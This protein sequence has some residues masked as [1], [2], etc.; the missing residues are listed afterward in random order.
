MR[1]V[2]AAGE[3]NPRGEPQAGRLWSQQVTSALKSEILALA[4]EGGM[5]AIAAFAT[6]EDARLVTRVLGEYREMPGLAL[7]LK[8]AVRLWGC[9]EATVQRIVDVLVERR[10]LRWSRDGRVVRAE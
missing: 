8:Q 1:E 7:T 3:G 10:I 6:E 5:A 2:Q 4:R 9:D